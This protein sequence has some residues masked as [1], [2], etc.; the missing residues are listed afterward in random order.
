MP[1]GKFPMMEEQ[2]DFGG[3]S[4]RWWCTWSVKQRRLWKLVRRQ[5]RHKGKKP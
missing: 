4:W 1:E 3:S 2:I 5:Q